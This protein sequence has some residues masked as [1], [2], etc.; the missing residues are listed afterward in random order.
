MFNVL[1][2]YA[3]KCN[4]SKYRYTV[5]SFKKYLKEKDILQKNQW[6]MFAFFP[7][8]GIVI[9]NQPI[10]EQILQVSALGQENMNRMWR[11]RKGIKEPVRRDWWNDKVE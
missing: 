3:S 7:K 4:G 9:L 10:E 2:E 6:K 5:I 11:Q 8:N 1:R